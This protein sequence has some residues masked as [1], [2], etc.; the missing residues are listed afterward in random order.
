MN[1][2]VR[3]P[4]TDALLSMQEAERRRPAH[5]NVRETKNA[6]EAWESSYRETAIEGSTGIGTPPQPHMARGS[7]NLVYS[8]R[9]HLTKW[10]AT[11]QLARLSCRTATLTVLDMCG[12]RHR[13]LPPSVPQALLVHARQE[14]Q[15]QKIEYAWLLDLALPDNFHDPPELTQH[16]LLSAVALNVA[17]EFP[18]PEVRVRLRSGR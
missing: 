12:L 18:G 13:E 17:L 8:Q 9:R 3:S 16:P 5:E 6:L 7:F 4:R 15:C 2:S 11:A 14:V 10:A 1:L